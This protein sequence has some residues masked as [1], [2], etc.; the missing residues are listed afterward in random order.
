[1]IDY[2]K[3]YIKYKSKYLN[4]I[5]GVE[6]CLDPC[7][8]Q[9]KQFDYRNTFFDTQHT[10]LSARETFSSI[11]EKFTRKYDSL[12]S[13]VRRACK[14]AEDIDKLN[15]LMLSLL[16]GY[17]VKSTGLMTDKM[18]NLKKTIEVQQ[19]LTDKNFPTNIDDFI[20]ALSKIAQIIINII[21]REVS[22]RSYRIYL[23]LNG[24]DRNYQFDSKKFLIFPVLFLREAFEILKLKKTSELQNL[25]E[26]LAEILEIVELNFPPNFKFELRIYDESQAIIKHLEACTFGEFKKKFNEF[27]KATNKSTESSED[28]TT[29]LEK[30]LEVWNFA[31]K[32][33][34]NIK[35]EFPDKKDIA[36]LELLKLLIPIGNIFIKEV[37]IT[38]TNKEKFDK[39][40]ETMQKKISSTSGFFSS[41]FQ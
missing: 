12:K 13:D 16:L 25:D 40:K 23:P 22:L 10:E 30:F 31:E 27:R 39:L 15:N 1:M 35:C 33:A 21:K 4:L 34:R 8:D 7:L 37:S 17:I 28:I 20:T 2:K 5:G 29:L 3:K 9:F 11:Q 18:D 24:Q 41:L 26:I 32:E 36:R 38:G 19:S 6:P 14:T